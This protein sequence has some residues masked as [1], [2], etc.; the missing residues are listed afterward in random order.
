M[1]QQDLHD[2]SASIG[3]AV[4][5]AHWHDP[6]TIWA[7]VDDGFYRRLFR[8]PPSGTPARI[9][10]PLS[11]VAFDVAPDGSIA[12]AG[13]DFAHLQEI[14]LRSPDGR[15]RQLTHIQQGVAN[16]RLAPTNIFKT[17]SFDGTEI[18][19]SL[20]KPAA[21]PKHNKMPLVL[22]VLWSMVSR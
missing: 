5:Q 19:A 12:F 4:I 2:V 20:M 8:L 15:I 9:D 18:E 21:P 13:E 14:Y 6:A 11:V 22:L 17:K 16:A 7:M 10:I 3:L 1:G